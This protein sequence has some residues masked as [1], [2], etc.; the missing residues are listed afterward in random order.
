MFAQKVQ[1]L[2]GMA[3]A[4]AVADQHVDVLADPFGPE[5]GGGKARRHREKVDGPAVARREDRRHLGPR[6]ADAAD[7]QVVL[8]A[9][10]LGSQLGQ[11]ERF[12]GIGS[13]HLIKQPE[14]LGIRGCPGVALDAD[15]LRYTRPACGGCDDKARLAA[16]A[17]DQRP[18]HRA[19]PAPPSRE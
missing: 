6:G 9:A 2:V 3:G 4:V 8:P 1:R 13:Q 10:R 17:E 16:A 12:G 7:D 5:R 15:D 11:G 19:P 14:R 18:Q